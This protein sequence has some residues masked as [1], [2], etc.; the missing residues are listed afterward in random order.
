MIEDEGPRCSISEKL[1]SKNREWANGYRIMLATKS[2][3]HIPR[4][5]NAVT[6]YLTVDDPE[7]LVAFAKTAFEA[8]EIKDQRAE[9]PNGKL[10]HTAVRLEGYSLEIG[11]ASDQWKAFPSAIHLFVR[12]VDA[13]YSRALKAG[14][15][16]LHEVRDMEYGE[17]SGAVRDPSGNHWYIA[18]YTGGR[19]KKS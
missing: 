5:L 2:V 7:G 15:V 16:S 10:M 12:D 6:P 19:E 4:G 17:R 1:N 9:G 13:T 11:R 3:S 18:T 14:G 8:E